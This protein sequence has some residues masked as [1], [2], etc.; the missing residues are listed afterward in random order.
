V[1]HKSRA[2]PS[3]TGFQYTTLDLSG[4]V[5][6]VEVEVKKFMMQTR[7]FVRDDSGQDLLEYGLLAAFISI[8]AVAAVTNSGQAVNSLFSMAATMMQQAA[9]AAGA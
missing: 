1:A 6:A 9:Q 5:V 7:K 3:R 2:V 4:R 8:V